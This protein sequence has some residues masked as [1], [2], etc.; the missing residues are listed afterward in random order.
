M[1]QFRNPVGH[2][3][4]ILTYRDALRQWSGSNKDKYKVASIAIAEFKRIGIAACVFGSLAFRLLG[5]GCKPNV[6]SARL[7]CIH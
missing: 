2:Q 5:V 1:S 6:C 4:H 7:L 3:E